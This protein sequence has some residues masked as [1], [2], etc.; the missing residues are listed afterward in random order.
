MNRMR[1]VEGR[2]VDV[3]SNALARASLGILAAFMVVAILPLARWSIHAGSWAPLAIHVL[4]LAAVVHIGWSAR[5]PRTVRAWTPLAFIPLLYVE[6]RWIIAGAG[7]LHADALIAGWDIR[8]FGSEPSRTL[9]LRWPSLALSEL[10]HLCYLAYYAIVYV[11][12]ALLWW[13]SRHRAFAA[14]VFAIVV[15]YV[16]C[17][18]AFVIL[19]VEGPRF[20]VGPSAAPD[21][22]IRSIVLQILGVGSSRG[23]AFPSAHVA[24]S[25]VA[26]I[27]ALRFQRALG[28]AILVITAGMMIGAVY[29]GYH[30]A[31][32]V[33]AGMAM[34]VGAAALARAAERFIVARSTTRR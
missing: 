28:V 21:G 27:S 32:D 12:P 24:A 1:E 11:P 15:M 10:L 7:R 9:A 31:V 5:V 19:P 20:L 3:E 14:T 2:V 13:K 6:L 33:I 26:G 22:P 29:G 23:T 4:A 34:G 25:V 18:I 8:L 16:L 17:F 30:Y